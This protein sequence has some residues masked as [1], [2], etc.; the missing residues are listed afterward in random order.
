MNTR[1]MVGLSQRFALGLAAVVL[2]LA[3]AA[4]AAP[5]PPLQGRPFDIHVDTTHGYKSTLIMTQVTG[6]GPWTF[7]GTLQQA[8]GAQWP[9]T[10]QFSQ[11][12]EGGCK[13]SF[14][15]RPSSSY[16]ETYEGA[17]RAD[18]IHDS[19]SPVFVAGQYY[20]YQR[21]LHR[22]RVGVTYATWVDGPRPFCA[23]CPVGGIIIF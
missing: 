13:I 14:T 20:I 8:N 23:Q 19:T 11:Q 12:P 22:S 7:I 15:A 5:V 18:N 17:L 1:R 3:S 10:G 21:L 9:V 4:E 6:A 2:C 16:W